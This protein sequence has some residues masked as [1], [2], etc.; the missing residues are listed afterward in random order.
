[1]IHFN[2]NRWFVA[3]SLFV[4]ASQGST[5][6]VRAALLAADLGSLSAGSLE[7]QY[8]STRLYQITLNE[9]TVDSQVLW[10]ILQRGPENTSL[11]WAKMDLCSILREKIDRR[12][13]AVG[14]PQTWCMRPG[15]AAQ[16]RR[17]QRDVGP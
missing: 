5:R 16:E 4:C 2:L 17:G 1:M 10:R 14:D 12:L 6:V 7:A 15:Y 8:R 9:I 11:Q 3:Q 13:P